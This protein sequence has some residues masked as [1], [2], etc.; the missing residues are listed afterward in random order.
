MR[1]LTERA[2]QLSAY[3]VEDRLKAFLLSHAAEAGG[4]R[5]GA[6][7]PGLPTHAEIA[8][9]IGA[10]R[11]AVSRALSML[12]QNGVLSLQ[13]GTLTIHNPDSLIP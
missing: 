6:A 13:R 10:N 11:E 3:S 12:R 4:L 2:C 8:A 9:R 7:M 1:D 5:P